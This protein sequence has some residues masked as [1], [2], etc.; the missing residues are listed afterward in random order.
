MT[1]A[2]TIV[3][4]A[5]AVFCVIAAIRTSVK[6]FIEWDVN[7]LGNTRNR[8]YKKEEYTRNIIAKKHGKGAEKI[9][10][11][12]YDSYRSQKK[13]LRRNDVYKMFARA[14]RNAIMLAKNYM[15]EDDID[16]IKEIPYTCLNDYSIMYRKFFGDGVFNPYSKIIY[17][18]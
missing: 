17:A 4:I 11:D 12:A 14:Y 16:Y 10:R 1:Y 5:L 7:S 15:D 9:M 6:K 3:V 2:Y 8:D 13:S 18:L